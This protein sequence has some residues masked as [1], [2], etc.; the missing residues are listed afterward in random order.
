MNL[1]KSARGAPCT[2][3]LPDCAPGPENNT[4]VLCHYKG[5]GMALKHNDRYA[6]YGCS[7]C[8]ALL[9]GPESDL[10]MPYDEIFARALGLTRIYQQ[11]H[12]L[13]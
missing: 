11:R 3:R 1:R 10:P 12:N 4:V 5:A 13:L 7:A 8:H 6:V 2:L 9:D